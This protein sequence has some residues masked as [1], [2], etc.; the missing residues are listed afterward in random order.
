[1]QQSECVALWIARYSKSTVVFQFPIAASSCDPESMTLLAF[2]PHNADRRYQGRSGQCLAPLSKDP[3]RPRHRSAK[4]GNGLLCDHSDGI[5][6]RSDSPSTPL[7]FEACFSEYIFR[8]AAMHRD[9]AVVP[10]SGK[11]VIPTLAPMRTV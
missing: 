5:M 9:S 6:E 2:L 8:S 3:E 11:R 7:V 1:M 10:S 4:I